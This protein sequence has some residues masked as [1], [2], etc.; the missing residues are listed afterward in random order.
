MLAIFLTDPQM[1]TKF[2]NYHNTQEDTYSPT[3]L[4]AMNPAHY[5]RSLIQTFPTWTFLTTCKQVLICIY[6]NQREFSLVLS[7]PVFQ[8]SKRRYWSKANK[9]VT[10]EIDKGKVKLPYRQPAPNRVWSWTASSQ[11]TPRAGQA[12]KTA[13]LSS[14]AGV[15]WKWWEGPRTHSQHVTQQLP[16]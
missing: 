15:N 4:S 6:I 8:W 14:T 16:L 3:D 7:T 12:W 13:E 11:T 5:V 2:M 1:K 10:R 9:S